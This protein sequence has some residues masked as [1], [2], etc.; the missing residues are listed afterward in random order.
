MKIIVLG[1]GAIGSLYGSKLSSLNKVTLIARK[2]HADEINKN[3]LRIIG[4]ENKTFNI[5]AVTKIKNIEKNT[6]ILL[7]SKV[8]DNEKSIIGIKNLIKNDT[9]IL[10][11]QNG[12]CSEDIVKKIVGK[13]CL[14]LR[15]VTNF[16]AVFLKPGVVEYKNYSYTSIEKSRASGKIAENFKQCGL[17][18]FVS[19]NIKFDMWKKLVFNCV[20]NP[21]TAILKIE[22]RVITDERLD[23]L[24][25]L[26]ADEC[27]KVAEK[28]GIN[29]KIDFVRTINIEFK[30][31]RNVS[32]MRQDL[33]KGKKTEIDYLNGAVASLGKKYGVNCPVNESL[34]DIIKFLEKK[35]RSS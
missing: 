2:S 3:G 27:V 29:F 31:S 12:L 19:S 20:L 4:L 26:I 32:S 22:N 35:G 7:T 21:V 14:V 1:A 6:L 13:K 30:N 25:K 11:L 15:G 9:I 28:D 16:G 34:A 5:K 23:S 8:Y 33:M 10:C 18:G 17:N 24:K